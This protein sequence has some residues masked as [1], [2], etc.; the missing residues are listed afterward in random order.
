[1]RMTLQDLEDVLLQAD[2]GVETAM[3]IIRFALSAARYGKDIFA[4]SEFRKV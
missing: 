3:R 2:L 1:M 4:P